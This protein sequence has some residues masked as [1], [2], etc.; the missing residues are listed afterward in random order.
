MVTATPPRASNTYGSDR[1]RR[2]YSIRDGYRSEL[3]LPLPPY[4][5]MR[6]LIER[7]DEEGVV[8]SVEPLTG[9]VGVGRSVA[10]SLDALRGALRRHHEF[11]RDVGPDHLSGEFGRHLERLN[12]LE[13]AHS[14]S[15]RLSA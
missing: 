5:T 12:L 4:R 11:L 6:V 9:R 8:I 7:D 2:S 1:A 10:L 14:D 15:S 3:Q 13:D